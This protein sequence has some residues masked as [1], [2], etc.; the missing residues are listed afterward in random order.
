MDGL[1]NSQHL[2]LVRLPM[3]QGFEEEMSMMESVER[4]ELGETIVKDPTKIDSEG[5]AP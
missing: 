2:S 1:A 3:C 5:A 4:L